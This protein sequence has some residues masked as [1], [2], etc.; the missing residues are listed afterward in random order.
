MKPDI[1]KFV[2]STILALAIL[3]ATSFF[4]NQPLI[5]T[6][7]LIVLSVLMFL[8][9]PKGSNAILYFFGFIFGPVSEAI[10]VHFGTWNYTLPLV[11]GIPMWL[12]LVWGDCG[13]YIVRAKALIDD[14]L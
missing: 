3:L 4:W 2:I 13:L 6:G 8:V 10:A 1:K 7:V 14:L 11:V 5:A 12:P 9:E